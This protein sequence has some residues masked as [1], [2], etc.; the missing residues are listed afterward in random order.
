VP[1]RRIN[2]EATALSSVFVEKHPQL[3]DVLDPAPAPMLGCA[4]LAQ[5]VRRLAAQLR[6]S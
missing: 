5:H 4:V 3:A 1:S 6:P 2:A